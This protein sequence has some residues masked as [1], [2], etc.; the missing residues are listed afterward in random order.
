MDYNGNLNMVS[1]QL[2]LVFI[3][4]SVTKEVLDEVQILS[5]SSV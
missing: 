1:I 2:D 5:C 4:F 3:T